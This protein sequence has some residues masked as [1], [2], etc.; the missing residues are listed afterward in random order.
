MKSKEILMEVVR[1]SNVQIDPFK[2]LK[3]RKLNRTI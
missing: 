2:C 3:G 1:D